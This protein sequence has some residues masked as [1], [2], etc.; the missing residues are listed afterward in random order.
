MAYRRA[1]GTGFGGSGRSGWRRSGC[2]AMDSSGGADLPHSPGW[3]YNH[4]WIQRPPEGPLIAMMQFQI[5]WMKRR[6]LI[7]LQVSQSPWAPLPPKPAQRRRKLAGAGFGPSNPFYAPSTLPFQ[8]PPFDKIKDSDY[9]PAID[10]GMAQQIEGGRGDRQQSRA[11]D[12][13]K[14]A[15]GAGALGPVAR[16][17]RGWHSTASPARI[18]TTSCKRCR[19][20]EAPRLA[21]HQDAIYLNCQTVCAREGDL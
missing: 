20:Y 12:L 17:A 14:H 16:P 8:A 5:Y 11:A 1:G 18:P 15:G 9:K 19:T 10:A 21:A 2:A 7:K 6:I 3:A 4:G 13:R